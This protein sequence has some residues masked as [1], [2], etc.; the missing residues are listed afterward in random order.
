[1]VRSD[2]R[3]ATGSLP[4]S[5][6]LPARSAELCT[7][8]AG[9]SGKLAVYDEGTTSW[10]FTTLTTG[11]AVYVQDEAVVYIYSGTWPSGTWAVADWN[12]SA[13]DDIVLVLLYE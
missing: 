9:R 7:H 11:M 10:T 2:T 13:V 3:G 5:S 12:F 4:R 6:L 8:R 1:M